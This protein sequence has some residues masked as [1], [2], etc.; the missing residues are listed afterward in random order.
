MGDGLGEADGG[1][2]T[3]H[4]PS[5]PPSQSERGK[6]SETAS[7]LGSRKTDVQERKLVHF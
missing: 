1:R 4:Q 7:G 2:T 6:Q 5:V 3:L